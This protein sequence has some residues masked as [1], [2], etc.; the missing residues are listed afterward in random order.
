MNMH[1]ALWNL[2]YHSRLNALILEDLIEEYNFFI[3]NKSER[4]TQLLSQKILVIDLVLTI[5]AFRLLTL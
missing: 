3:N 1:S 4:S 2:H 5:S